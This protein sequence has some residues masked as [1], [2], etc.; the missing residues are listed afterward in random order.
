M[1]KN[2]RIPSWLLSATIKAHIK[3]SLHPKHHNKMEQWN[4]KI[5]LFR[6]WCMSCYTTKSCPNPSGEKQLTLLAIH[7]TGCISDLI[8]RRLSMNSREERSQLLS[9]SGYLVVILTFY[10]IERTQKNLMQRVT[11]DF[12]QGTPLLVEHIECII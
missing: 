1:E 7:S 6:R 10:V 5:E 9:I 11:R 12:F 4:G 2:L 3:N 8:P